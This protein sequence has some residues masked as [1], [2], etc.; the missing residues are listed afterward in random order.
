MRLV[1]K[2]NAI[3]A[4]KRCGSSGSISTYAKTRT[5]RL[6]NIKCPTCGG[7]MIFEKRPRS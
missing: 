1:E 6:A 4:N 5:T 7:H 2:R 3:C